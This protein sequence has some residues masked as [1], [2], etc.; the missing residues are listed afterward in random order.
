VI[1]AAT[2]FV[3]AIAAFAAM[4]PKTAILDSDT[5]DD[6][7]GGF[8]TLPEGRAASVSER[9]Y[10]RRRGEQLLLLYGSNQLLFG[11]PMHDNFFDL[12]AMNVPAWQLMLRGS[13]M[14]WVL[15]LM[16]RFVMRREV[17]GVGIADI[18]VLV[19]LADASQ[20]AMAGEYTTIAEGV[21]LVATI[22]GWNVLFDWLAFRYQ[23]F[24]RFVEPPAVTLVRN[25]RVLHRN[26]RREFVTLDELMSKLRTQGIDDLSLVKRA[27]I[28]GD[29]KISII[30][31]D[32]TS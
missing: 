6:Y 10:V 18:L 7:V 28:E 24:A 1:P 30:T 26:L 31:F 19:L 4:A 25:G 13:V 23:G 14:Y 12:F 17:G 22:V 11:P 8:Q 29:G 16:L 20:N 5:A 27:C 3:S 2:N 21:V 15:F 9:A 32:R